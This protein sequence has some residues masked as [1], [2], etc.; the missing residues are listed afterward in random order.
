MHTFTCEDSVMALISHPELFPHLEVLR[1][2][3]ESLRLSTTKIRVKLRLPHLKKLDFRGCLVKIDEQFS[4]VESKYGGKKV[5]VDSTY[6]KKV[7]Q[8][9]LGRNYARVKW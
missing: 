7:K 3:C 4:Q 8:K 6:V 1:V 5:Q 9:A 2:K